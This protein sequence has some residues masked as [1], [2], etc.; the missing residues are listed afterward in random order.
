[1]ARSQTDHI[2]SRVYMKLGLLTD[3]QKSQNIYQI[4]GEL[5]Q[6][7]LVTPIAGSTTGKIT[8]RL[9]ETFLKVYAPDTYFHISSKNDEWVGDF[10]LFGV[11]FNTI[12]SV[13]SYSV[14]ER[15]LTSGSGSALCPTILYCHL[16]K[17]NYSDFDRP[18]RLQSYKIR[19]FT[20]VYLPKDTYDCLSKTAK[21]FKNINQKPF[22]RKIENFGPDTQSSII[23]KKIS[24]STRF[25]INPLML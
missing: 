5:A 16:L 10:G 21:E 19:G 15:A 8:E 4:I 23:T 9:V 22:L 18:D 20:S 17:K 6:I 7:N 24:G 13:K 1:M 12:I 14:K 11:P 3:Q 25:V 2:L